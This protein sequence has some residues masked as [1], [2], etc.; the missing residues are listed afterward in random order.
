MFDCKAEKLTNAAMF[1]YRRTK[2]RR[3]SRNRRWSWQQQPSEYPAN[4]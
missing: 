3:Y 4:D 2:P 1:K